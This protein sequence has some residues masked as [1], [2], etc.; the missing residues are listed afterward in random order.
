MVLYDFCLCGTVSDSFD[1]SEDTQRE[2]EETFTLLARYLGY[3]PNSQSP[4]S[5]LFPTPPSSTILATQALPVGV[6]H[7]EMVDWQV[8]RCFGRQPTF[9][10]YGTTCCK[11]TSTRLAGCDYM[12]AHMWSSHTDVFALVGTLRPDNGG[13][14]CIRVHFFYR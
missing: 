8:W 2:R 5:V 11:K 9:F 12:S 4:L 6:W 14:A 13:F 7:A 10:T 1:L 3:R